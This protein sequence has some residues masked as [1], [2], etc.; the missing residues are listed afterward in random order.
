[1]S[2]LIARSASSTVSS[3]A[4]TFASGVVSPISRNTLVSRRNLIS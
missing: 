4:A 3:H 1:V 2:A